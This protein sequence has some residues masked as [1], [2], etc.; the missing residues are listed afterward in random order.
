MSA[1]DGFRSG[2]EQIPTQLFSELLPAID[3]FDELRVTLFGLY[4]LNQFAGDERYILIDDFLEMNEVATTFGTDETIVQS[5]VRA[6]LEHAI[7]RGT[8]L[9]VSYG[10][11]QLIFLNSPKGRRAI[12]K[13]ENGEWAPDAFLHLS[14]T[15]NVSRP[16]IFQLYEDNIGPLTPMIADRL[17]VAEETYRAEWIE[18]AIEQAVMNNARNWRYIEAI[19]RSWKENGRSGFERNDR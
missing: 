5:R 16:N 15:V 18:D 8:F 13:L 12:A 11:D 2:I 6:G 10:N 3:D 14:E 17:K 1:F 4:L 7:A 19:L 9:T